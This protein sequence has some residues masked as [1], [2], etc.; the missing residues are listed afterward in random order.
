[1]LLLTISLFL[2]FSILLVISGGYLVK[3]ILR[4]ASFL[5]L[6][7]F[8][9]AFIIMAFSTS[10]PELFVGISSALNGNPALS[11]GNVIGSNIADVSIII[12][13]AALVKKGVRT[14]NQ[15]I[16]KDSLFMFVVACIPILLMVFDKTLSKIDGFILIIVFVVYVWHLINE[17]RQVEL[18]GKKVINNHNN[19][20]VVL[21]VLLF[22]V[23]LG[24]L[25]LSAH[26][27]VTYATQLAIELMLPSILIGLFLLALGT[28]LPELIFEMRAVLAR[29][30]DLALGDAMGSVVCNSTLVLGITA[31]IHPITNG[32][33]LFVTSSIF[34]IFMLFL[35]MAL[36]KRRKGLSITG[37]VVLILMYILFI[38]FEFYFKSKIS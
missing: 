6:S 13:I 7:E 3:L 16:K 28:S 18:L 31:L 15:Y 5:K 26:F 17:R 9:V 21:T 27:V 24:V 33:L 38:L 20:Q 12:G 19:Q 14:K 34:M 25:F 23:C 36:I 35:F 22:I 1:M 11:L 30:D 8:V 32:F 29:K 10:I 2:L 4:I 37:A